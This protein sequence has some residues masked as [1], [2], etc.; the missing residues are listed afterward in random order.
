MYCS[1]S[2]P[3][4]YKKTETDK[5]ILAVPSTVINNETSRLIKQSK[6]AL[7][8]N[9]YW[10]QLWWSNMRICY[11]QWVMGVYAWIAKRVSSQYNNKGAAWSV[12]F[13]ISLLKLL[14]TQLMHIMYFFKHYNYLKTILPKIATTMSSLRISMEPRDRK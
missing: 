2:Q 7:F 5:S 10:P 12:Y 4:H 3:V 13:M 9:T 1:Y 8:Q 14:F 11:Y 6:S